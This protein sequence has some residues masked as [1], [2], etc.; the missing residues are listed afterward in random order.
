M[1]IY[2]IMVKVWNHHNESSYIVPFEVHR[3]RQKALDNIDKYN[4][5]SKTAS[6]WLEAM[7][8]YQDTKLAENPNL[9]DFEIESLYMVECPISDEICKHADKDY[10]LVVSELVD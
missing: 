5:Y 8:Q 6:D 9:K 3:H 2:I 4:D 7:E 10:Y 1:E